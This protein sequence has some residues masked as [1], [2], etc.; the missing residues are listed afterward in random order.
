MSTPSLEVAERLMAA[1]QA[2]DVDA[3]REL[4]HPDVQVWHNFDQVCQTR[5]ENL[6]VLRWM[7]RRVKDRRYEEVRRFE[8]PGGFAQQHVL[9]GIAPNGELLECPAAIFC[10]VEDGLI[11]RLDEYLDSAQT[12]VLSR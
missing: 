11:T 9:R 3:V 1:I 12:A 8:T 10:T 2:G 4:Y 5:E 6:R 7:V